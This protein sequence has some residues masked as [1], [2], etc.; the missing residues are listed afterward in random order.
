MVTGTSLINPEEAA[1]EVTG[2][3]EVL[4]NAVVDPEKIGS[5][6]VV[7]ELL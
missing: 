4:D 6:E 5:K 2:A 3:L 1:S 7:T